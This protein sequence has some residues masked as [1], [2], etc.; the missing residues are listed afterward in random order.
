MNEQ[1]PSN[2][3]DLIKNGMLSSKESPGFIGF[4]NTLLCV[5]FKQPDADIVAFIRHWTGLFGQPD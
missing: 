2:N 4:V 1:H 3:F 5:V